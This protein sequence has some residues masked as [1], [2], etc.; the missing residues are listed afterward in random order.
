MWVRIGSGA[1][2]NTI[3]G[4]ILNVISGNQ[5]DGIEIHNPNTASNVVNSDNLIGTDA[6]GATPIPNGGNGVEISDGRPRTRSARARA[7]AT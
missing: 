3:G 7:S 1:T 4:G 2:A 6:T 5:S